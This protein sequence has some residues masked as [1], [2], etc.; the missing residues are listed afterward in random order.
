MIYAQPPVLA[1]HESNLREL[2]TQVSWGPGRGGL[3]V[4]TWA[5]VTDSW[6]H[7]SARLDP[8]LA[9]LPHAEALARA[10]RA[11]ARSIPEPAPEY[12]PRWAEPLI[13]CWRG[14]CRICGTRRSRRR[15]LH[16]TAGT[17]AG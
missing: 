6:A 15:Y 7:S 13:E 17:G 5:A 12:P 3:W 16:P 10:T 9:Q 2:I 8:T 11:A 14:C 4:H 1:R